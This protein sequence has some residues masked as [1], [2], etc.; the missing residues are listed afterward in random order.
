MYRNSNISFN[1]KCNFIPKNGIL[2]PIIVWGEDYFFYL[3][4]IR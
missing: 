2:S 3:G 4:K 1:K